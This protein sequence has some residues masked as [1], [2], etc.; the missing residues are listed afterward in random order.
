MPVHRGLRGGERRNA[1]GQCGLVLG[2]RGRLA[3]TEDFGL[4]RQVRHLARGVDEPGDQ[5]LQRLGVIQDRR[6]CQRP[7]HRVLPRQV[8]DGLLRLAELGH[9]RRQ[10][11]RVRQRWGGARSAMAVVR[12]AARQRWWSVRSARRS[13]APALP[14]PAGLAGPRAAAGPPP[15]SSAADGWAGRPAGPARAEPAARPAPDTPRTPRGPPPGLLAHTSGPPPA[16]AP[17]A[18]GSPARAGGGA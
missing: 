16:P 8:G 17:P 1:T 3:S 10:R 14:C 11:L 18:G 13:A 2:G 7:Q 12:A 15:D 4:P 6:C 9:H 5:L